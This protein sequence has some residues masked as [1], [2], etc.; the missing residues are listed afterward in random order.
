MEKRTKRSR[1]GAR[2]YGNS[3]TRNDQISSKKKSEK[4]KKKSKE[5][6]TD[7]K[8]SSVKKIEKSKTITTKSRKK[9]KQVKGEKFTI[10]QSPQQLKKFKRSREKVQN[11]MTG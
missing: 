10:E 4:L 7:A 1:K 11:Y 6:G 3:S 2:K 9:S 5:A 8:H